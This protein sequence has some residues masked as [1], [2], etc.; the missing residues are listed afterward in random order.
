MSVSSSP[1]SFSPPSAEGGMSP[2][3]IAIRRVA[4]R[5]FIGLTWVFAAVLPGLA[6]Y[7]DKSLIG[8][9]GIGVGFAIVATGLWLKD[10]VGRRTRTTIATVLTAQ[11]MVLLY[12]LGGT[13]DGFILDG[14]MVFF[15]LNAQ[16]L[17]Y[18]CWR[19]ILIV[20]LMAT[21]HHVILSLGFPLLVWPSDS[22]VLGHFLIHAAYVVLVGGP[23]L[24]LS[25]RLYRLFNDSHAAIQ[26]AQAASAEASRLAR[27][28]EAKTAEA[29]A[30]R[31]RD[32][33]TLA[34]GFQNKVGSVITTVTRSTQDLGGASQ[35]LSNA[36]AGARERV[37][38]VA[39][40]FEELSSSV[41]TVSDTVET[42]SASLGDI[43][44]QVNRSSGIAS[45][46]VASVKETNDKVRGLAEAS[47]KIGEVIGLINDIASQTNLLALNA[48]IEAARAGDA[49]KGFAVV[50]NEVKSLATQTARATDEIGSQIRGV[51]SATQEAVT[52]IGRIGATIRE[53]DG[54][55]GRVATA[56]QTQGAATREI[57]GTLRQT[58]AAARE[59]SENMV[60]IETAVQQAAAMSRTVADAGATLGMEAGT[61]QKQVGDFLEEVRKG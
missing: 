10:A 30:Q 41:R 24:W 14:H 51:Q 17:A 46:A 9:L 21:V 25:V 39:A 40:A 34:D 47:Q 49:G 53:M 29:E 58:A 61:L 27:L 37:T 54:I 12:T 56:V 22:F 5:F 55:T 11:W 31:M 23:L 19:S 35:T 45:E 38:V 28:D 15:V 1:S 8:A 20:N 16:L 4:S 26:H 18:F 59:V 44:Q 33:R 50:A 13:P 32:T 57:A 2:D 48:T 60:G 52:A 7:L 36:V 6:V 3:L 43:D 42:L